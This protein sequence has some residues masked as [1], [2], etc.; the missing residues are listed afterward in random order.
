VEKTVRGFI[1]GPEPCFSGRMGVDGGEG[2][3][4]SGN[5]AGACLR[6]GGKVAAMMQAPPTEHPRSI[7]R[8]GNLIERQE[9]I[10]EEDE[11]KK[12]APGCG[13]TVI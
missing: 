8:R 12:R 11:R 3:G 2:G 5:T 9:G 10:P 13:K 1:K 7:K 6:E 4:K